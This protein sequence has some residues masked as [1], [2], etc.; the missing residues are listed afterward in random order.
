MYESLM[1]SFF[2]GKKYIFRKKPF[3]INSRV[4]SNFSRN[5]VK[6]RIYTRRRWIF[7]IYMYHFSYRWFIKHDQFFEYT[8][9]QHHGSEKNSGDDP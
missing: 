7:I 2:V 5:N 8:S 3:N 4:N 6:R 9:L 1:S